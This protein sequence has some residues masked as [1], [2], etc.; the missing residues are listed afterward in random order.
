MYNA[1]EMVRPLI[2][3]SLSLLVS[4]SAL[5]DT[6]ETRFFRVEP[7]AW[8]VSRN[9]TGLWTLSQPSPEARVQFTVSRLNTTPA[10][11]LKAQAAVWARIGEI[12]SLD[13]LT[14]ERENQAWFLVK[15]LDDDL[16]TIKWVQWEG[17]LLVVTSFQSKESEQPSLLESFTAIAQSVE[18]NSPTYHEE[19]LRQEIER[20]LR[21]NTDSK[22]ELSSPDE[23]RQQMG[24]ARQD[25]EPF[26][27][28][29]TPPIYRPYLAYLES[30]FDAA[31]A[32]AHGEELGIGPELVEARLRSVKYRRDELEAALQGNFPEL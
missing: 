7:G 2:W 14:P 9:D 29:D 22:D 20:V 16:A 30:R 25:W 10:V 31:F 17:S 28:A 24:V 6:L 19:S 13:P 15:H 23:S 11:Y 21:A 12:G 26:F 18:L 3:L 4:G 32:V 27:L 1:S 8:S 5:A